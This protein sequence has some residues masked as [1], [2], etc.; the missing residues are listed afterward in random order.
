MIF[1]LLSLPFC[2]LPPTTLTQISK[3][4]LKL[5]QPL[6]LRWQHVFDNSENISLTSDEKRV[7]ASQTGGT[8]ISLGSNNG[9]M[10]WKTET[11]GEFTANPV[12]N[13][14]GVFVAS[15]ALSISSEMMPPKQTRQDG[16]MVRLLARESGITL[17]KKALPIPLRGTMVMDGA[18]LYGCDG[19]GRIFSL[20]L[21]SGEINWV[22]QIS[23]S[24][25]NE[26]TLDDAKIFA[27]G[28][29]G[30]LTALNKI[31]GTTSWRYQ[32]HSPSQGHLSLFENSLYFGSS[33][34]WVYAL[35]KDRGQQLWKTRVGVGVQF[36]KATKDGLFVASPDNFIY[37]LSSTRGNRLWKHLLPGKVAA[38][39]LVEGDALLAT[40]ISSREGIVLD[41]R[42]GRQINI[43]PLGDDSSSSAT[44][45]ISDETLLLATRH[46][47]LAFSQP[48]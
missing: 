7:Y 30:A 11:G 22:S 19:N 27:I 29:D 41:I 43:I 9:Q 12:S 47:L 25:L 16:G 10:L 38:P 24:S 3:S 42:N 31:T 18:S 28:S 15:E 20:K 33:N 6:N 23:N 5:S 17:W 1:I 48:N 44:P 13:E 46:A 8:I 32:T 21:E 37:C 40:L 34:G 36:I 35:E 26:L 2:H 4:Q 14:M 45:L 39:L